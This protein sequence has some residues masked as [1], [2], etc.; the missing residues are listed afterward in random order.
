[1]SQSSLTAEPT[2]EQTGASTLLMDVNDEPIEPVSDGIGVTST[3]EALTKEHVM[4]L[5]DVQVENFLETDNEDD[6]CNTRTIKEGLLVELDSENDETLLMSTSHFDVHQENSAAAVFEP[7]VS[8][9]DNDCT[10]VAEL[11]RPTQDSLQHFDHNI[12]I[13]S[14][15]NVRLVYS[16]RHN[17]TELILSFKLTNQCQA[18]TA[19]EQVAMTI[20]P[21]SNL[22]S[23]VD[24]RSVAVETLAFLD[25]VGFDQC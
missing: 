9:D 10:A 7:A 16:T 5:A 17:A 6:T 12:E 15:S 19:V 18:R 8:H 2:V 25:N 22:V 21:P 13:C 11:L 23:D 1:M 14:D 24:S 20:E 3:E 4:S